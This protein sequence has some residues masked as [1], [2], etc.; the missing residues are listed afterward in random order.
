MEDVE[1]LTAFIKNYARAHG[2]P[3]PGRVPRHRDKVVV[4]PSDQTKMFVY[5]KYE[6]ACSVAGVPSLG[7][8]KFYDLW[9]SLLPFISVCS[10]SSDLCFTCQQQCLAIQ[11]AACLPEEEKIL[12]ISTAQAHIQRAK[13]EREYY[14]TQI[15]R[16]T[17][18]VQESQL[19]GVRPQAVHYSFDFAQQVH[20]PFDCQQTGPEYFKT[21]RKCGVF[22]VCND[23]THVQVNYLIDESENPGKGADCVISLLHHYLE[24]YGNGD[25]ICFC[26]LTIVLAKIKIM[27]PCTTCCGVYLQNKMKVLS[28]HSCLQDIQSF[29]WIVF[30]ACS[31]RHLGVHQLTQLKALQQLWNPPHRTSK[32]SHS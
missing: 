31:R 23:C 15:A 32:M 4:L 29:P 13:Q 25:V 20:F 24:K 16:C 5:R 14:N 1:R 12:R 27:Q 9:A 22:G 30:S 6:E 3:L 19:S 7:R 2:L 10:P 28:C 11:K 18:C 21:A 8:S 26:M 17:E